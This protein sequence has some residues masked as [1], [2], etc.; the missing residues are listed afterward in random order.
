VVGPA[1][2][3]RVV[4]VAVASGNEILLPQITPLTRGHTYTLS[5]TISA[6]GQALPA[7][8]VF[9][10]LIDSNGKVLKLHWERRGA[11]AASQSETV[12]LSYDVPST[13]IGP[14]KLS[15]LA[16]TDWL[17]AGGQPLEQTYTEVRYDVR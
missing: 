2:V 8:L 3:P 17:Q 7:H 1:A 13:V 15:A 5:T 9:V 6:G 11:L 12:S 10:Q 4:S 14:V 16:W